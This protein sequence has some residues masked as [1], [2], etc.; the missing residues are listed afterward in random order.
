MTTSNEPSVDSSPSPRVAPDFRPFPAGPGDTPESAVG[1]RIQFARKELGLSV[2]ALAR[3][4]A[5]FDSPVQKGISATSLLR[6]EAGENEPGAREIRILCDAFSASPR[7][8]IYGELDNPGTDAIEQE[9]VQVLQRYIEARVN[10]LRFEG[11]GPLPAFGR[12]TPEQRRDW[13]IA[14]RKRPPKL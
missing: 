4:T 10:T 3:Y 13:L 1:Q 8:L 9:L 14:A 11:V 5:Q 2:E 6:Y 7:W 12:P